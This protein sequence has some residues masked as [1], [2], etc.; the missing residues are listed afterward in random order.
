MSRLAVVCLACEAKLAAQPHYVIKVHVCLTDQDMFE[1]CAMHK[2]G[3]SW[4]AFHSKQ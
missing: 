2:I 3:E 1:D 4:L